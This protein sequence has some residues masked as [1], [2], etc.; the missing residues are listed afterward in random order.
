[1]T[2]K[3]YISGMACNHCKKSVEETLNSLNGVKSAVVYLENALA[4]VETENAIENGVFIEAI[5]DI[6]FTVD[7]VE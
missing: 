7:S 1:M 4:V 2:K 3:L 5:E 6:G